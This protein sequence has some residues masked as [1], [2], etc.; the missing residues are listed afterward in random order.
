MISQE[1]RTNRA[2]FPHA[3][4][5]KY[6]GSW[7]AFSADG[8]RVVASGETV[9]GLEDQLAAIGA[10]PQQTVMEWVAGPEDDILASGGEL[11]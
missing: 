9:D 7:V 11:L 3:E 10:D 8:C 6:Q 2:R 1:Y 5:A 4:L